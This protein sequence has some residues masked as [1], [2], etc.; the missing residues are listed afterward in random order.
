[1]LAS[2]L[3]AGI[4]RTNT[5]GLN[6]M[7]IYRQLLMPNSNSM[8]ESLKDKSD[9]LILYLNREA[10]LL[11]GLYREA[12]FSKNEVLFLA[13]WTQSPCHLV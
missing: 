3:I 7:R 1:M 4:W 2:L 9:V 5:A 10:G 11:I 6:L 8:K 12:A 13:L